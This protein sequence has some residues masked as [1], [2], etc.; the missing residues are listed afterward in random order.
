MLKGKHIE[1]RGIEIDDLHHLDAVENNPD[2]WL[3]SDTQ[4]PYSKANMLEYIKSVR[5]LSADK[6]IRFVISRRND[7]NFLG[8]I[9]LFEYHAIHRRAGVG[10]LIQP[11]YR[12]K[13][14]AKEALDLIINYAFSHLNLVQLWANILMNNSAS[15]VLF[16]Q[17]GFEKTGVKKKWIRHQNNWIDQGF[18]QLFDL[19]HS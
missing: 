1:L 2:N 10:V 13:G 17:F 9:D 12:Q 3:I 16:S 8:F 14:Y 11:D 4:I 7:G 15:I 19:N 18:F 5:D 6:Q